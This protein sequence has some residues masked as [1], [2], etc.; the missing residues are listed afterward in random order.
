M[1]NNSIVLPCIDFG[2]EGTGGGSMS[3]T[4]VEQIKQMIQDAISGITTIEFNIVQELPEVGE[5]KYIYLIKKVDDTGEEGEDP[6]VP[7]SETKIA[8]SQNVYD[9]YIWVEVEKKYEHI[10]STT[11]DLSN[12]YTKGDIGNSI[13]FRIVEF[14]TD[15]NGKVYCSYEVK[16]LTEKKVETKK[17][18]IPTATINSDG[19]MAKEDKT[20]VVNLQELE[21][22][23]ND[24]SN[25]SKGISVHNPF[26]DN[27]SITDKVFN[28]LAY[29]YEGYVNFLGW[30]WDYE[31]NTLKK[32]DTY[33]YLGLAGMF[34][35][36]KEKG[37]KSAG[38][39]TA[40]ERFKL[41]KLPNVMIIGIQV[42]GDGYTSG[43]K[44]NGN[45]ILIGLN[46][47]TY[48][49]GG[50]EPTNKAVNIKLPLAT[51]NSA[52]LISKEEETILSVEVASNKKWTASS[53]L[54]YNL[55]I[56]QNNT[57][58]VTTDVGY[59]IKG[60]TRYLSNGNVFLQSIYYDKTTGELKR[61]DSHRLDLAGSIES[62]GN[63][64]FNSGLVTANERRTIKK[65]PS[66]LFTALFTDTANGWHNGFKADSDKVTLAFEIT[67]ITQN[68]ETVSK[69]RIETNFPIAVIGWTDNGQQ[70][71]PTR[72][73][74][75]L[76]TIDD[77]GFVQAIRQRGLTGVSRFYDRKRQGESMGITFKAHNFATNMVVEETVWIDKVT[78]TLAGL[79][80]P[81]QKKKLDNVT[82]DVTSQEYSN[83]ISN[84][85]IDE[86]QLY[87]IID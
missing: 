78:D 47:F 25:I 33:Y 68:Q 15:E 67:D 80:T 14:N 52:G 60:N 10:G 81:D 70:V 54:G 31:T 13:C 73:K 7:L 20:T 44:A 1:E 51:V 48:T 61:I 53:I 83:L 26:T 17:V 8:E 84:G 11:V 55:A 85:Q 36:S 56:D 27:S 50:V 41:I 46:E 5:K 57:S 86:N 16:N 21:K 74:A 49:S 72:S 40:E 43:V 76:M 45:E 23:I 2:G 24:K 3:E 71:D 28:N 18:M 12:Y 9:E 42:D 32:D 22:Y 39:V 34:D 58:L 6:A 37:K 79:M 30:Y 4:T 64:K 77:I 87:C 63:Y 19:I 69:D 62:E 38:L 65:M 29:N 66:T 59:K 35:C 82:K 75:G